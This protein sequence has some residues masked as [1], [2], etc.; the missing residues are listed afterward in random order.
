VADATN[1]VRL[2]RYPNCGVWGG[3]VLPEDADRKP[4]DVNYAVPYIARPVAQDDAREERLKAAESAARVCREDAEINA[5]RAE[6]A[7][8]RANTATVAA[9]L[10]R[11]RAEKAEAELQTV[12]MRAYFWERCDKRGD[13]ECWPW[14]GTV[15]ASHGYGEAQ[16]GPR[17]SVRRWRAH[18]LSYAVFAGN[19]ADDL[20]VM[21]KCDNRVCVNPRHLSL[22][23]VADNNKDMESKGRDRPPNRG[24]TICK[25]GHPLDGD[26][27]YIKPNGARQCRACAVASKARWDLRRIDAALGDVPGDDVND[28]TFDVA[29]ADTRPDDSDRRG[30]DGAWVERG[31]E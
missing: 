28:E 9:N 30:E 16:I 26:N 10:L 20:V 4:D 29:E 19:I 15:N 25:N 5:A 21:H 24:K 12:E 3:L 31:H 14:R 22:G 7:E 6:K 18:R 27:L 8:A 17:G 11:D 23:T 1:E 2:W 13:D